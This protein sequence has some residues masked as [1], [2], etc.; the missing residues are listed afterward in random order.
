[1]ICQ[2]RLE[3]EATVVTGVPHQTLLADGKACKYL[4]I[5]LTDKK[6]P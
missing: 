3:G 1:V 4:V 6:S 5:K 2:D